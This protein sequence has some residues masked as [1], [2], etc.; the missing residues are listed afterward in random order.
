[1]RERLRR[2]PANAGMIAPRREGA[3]HMALLRGEEILA[4]RGHT[5]I[6][7]GM[8]RISSPDEVA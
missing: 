4:A 3:A 6:S 7:R 1:M 2:P 5:G 8:G